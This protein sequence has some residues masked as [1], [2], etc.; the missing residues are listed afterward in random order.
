MEMSNVI[1]HSALLKDSEYSN[2]KRSVTGDEQ[3]GCLSGPAVTVG[4]CSSCLPRV[5]VVAA[6]KEAEE[7]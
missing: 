5:Y 6:R 4:S 2:F 7:Y 3:S 1:G